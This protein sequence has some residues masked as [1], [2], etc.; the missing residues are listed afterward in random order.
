MYSKIMVPVDLAHVERL[1]KALKTAADLARQYGAQVCYV[2]VTSAAPGSVAHN[3]AEF[4]QHLDEL[5]ASQSKAHGMGISTHEVVSHDPAVDL[6][7]KLLDAVNETG[8]D[9][10]VMA[11][12]V[13]G[14]LEHI[15]SSNAGYVASHAKVSVFVVR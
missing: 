9:L 2:G 11:S 15:F 14:V 13:P 12:H 10:V 7:G 6:D 4:K 1:E 3:P 5:A 8:A